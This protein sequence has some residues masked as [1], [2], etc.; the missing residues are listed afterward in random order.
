MTPLNNLRARVL[1][2]SGEDRQLDAAIAAYLV[3]GHAYQIDGVWAISVPSYRAPSGEI[4]EP[5]YLTSSFDAALA[6]VEEKL[7]GCA[8]ALLVDV[9]LNVPFAIDSPLIPPLCR[10]II[11]MLLDELEAQDAPAQP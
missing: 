8:H 10:A 5:D 4:V 2:G 1:A 3:G 9:M 6:L 7:P 11:A